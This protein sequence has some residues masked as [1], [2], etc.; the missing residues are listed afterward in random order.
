MEYARGVKTN[1]IV[2]NVPLVQ[3]RSQSGEPGF[4]IAYF[5]KGCDVPVHTE[6][7]KVPIVAMVRELKPGLEGTNFHLDIYYHYPYNDWGPHARGTSNRCV[8][9]PG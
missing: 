3:T 1:R 6:H 5:N 7:Q 4:D 9:A 2:P 8:L